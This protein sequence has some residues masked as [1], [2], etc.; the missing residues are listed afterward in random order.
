MKGLLS[1]VWPGKVRH[2]KYSK[3]GKLL[4]LFSLRPKEEN[5]ATQQEL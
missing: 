1:E 3:N 2:T 4:H 5:T